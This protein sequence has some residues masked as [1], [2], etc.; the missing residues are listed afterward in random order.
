MGVKDGLAGS[1]S[2]VGAD[3][4]G[5]ATGLRHDA[6]D[7]LTEEQAESIKI[8]AIATQEIVGM[9]L[10]DDQG[11]PRCHGIE[12]LDGDV[13]HVLTARSRPTFLGMPDQPTESTIHSSV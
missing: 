3:V 4:H 13:M 2:Y 5:I 7:L 11:V 8:V 9:V 12:I 10:G 6:I 1:R